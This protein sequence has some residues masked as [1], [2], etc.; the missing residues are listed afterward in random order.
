MTFK[1]SARVGYLN[2]ILA[3]GGENLN[4]SIS[5]SSNARGIVR[6]GGGMLMFRIDRRITSHMMSPNPSLL[7]D[8]LNRGVT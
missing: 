4:K 3:Q 2:A 5:E 8:K 7:R 1:F 6:G